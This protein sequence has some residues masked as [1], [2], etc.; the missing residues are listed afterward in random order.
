[1]PNLNRG[2]ER[3]PARDTKRHVETGWDRVDPTL[4]RPRGWMTVGEKAG[5]R[6]EDAENDCS[7]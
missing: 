4:S 7:L 6:A 3:Q 5:R 2:P 1:M